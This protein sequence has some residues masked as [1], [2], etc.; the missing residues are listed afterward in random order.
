[1]TSSYGVFATEG[2]RYEPQAILSVEDRNGNVLEEFEPEG[3][4]RI[5]SENTTRKFLMFCQTTLH[6]HHFMEKILSCIS[7]QQMLLEKLVQQTTTKTLG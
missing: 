2:I 1:M 7:D 4:Q 6:V 5:L 3:G